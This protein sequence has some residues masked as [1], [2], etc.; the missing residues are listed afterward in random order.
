MEITEMKAKIQKLLNI[1]VLSPKEVPDILEFVCEL[2]DLE[3]QHDLEKYPN[4]K[5]SHKESQTAYKI[6][7][8]LEEFFNEQYKNAK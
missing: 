6:V 4:A 5:I 3:L 7:R 8:E 1:A 2:I